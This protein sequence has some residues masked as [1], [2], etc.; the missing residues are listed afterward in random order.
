MTR[1]AAT[2]EVQTVLGPVKPD[3][4]GITL[5]HEHLLLDLTCLFAEPDTARGRARARQPVSLENLSWIRRNWTSSLDNLR[6]DDEA[7]AV[8]EALEYRLDGGRTIVDV[9]SIGLA[10]DPLGLQRIARATGLHVVMGCG[11]YVARSHPAGMDSRSQQDIEDE[12]VRE[13]TRGVADTGVRA[14]IIGELG[15]SWPLAADE[16]KV[17]RAAARAQQRTGVAVSI[18]PGPGRDPAS[19]LQIIELL[20]AAGADLGRVIMGHLDRTGL[21]ADTLRK[22]AASGCYLAFD[23]FG[24]E[25]WV[26]PLGPF[27]RL[28]D[29]QRVDLIRELIAEGLGRQILVSHDVGYKHRLAAYGGSGYSHVLTT[30]LPYQM[31]R[32]GIREEQVQWLLVDNPARALQL[33]PAPR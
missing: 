6:L 26:Y 21:E 7:L 3:E 32:K 29:A 31:R 25:T 8:R 16:E 24:Q 5:V 10:R 27:D 18:H 17:L 28:S 23:T 11:Y 20:R 33:A 4:L 2:G 9:T 30:V 15:C 22:V 19:L 1:P 14:G 13:I 12:I